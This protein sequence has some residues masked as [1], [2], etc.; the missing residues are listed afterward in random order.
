LLIFGLG[1]WG[2]GNVGVGAGVKN[3]FDF[4]LLG[5]LDGFG[6]D[7]HKRKKNL[8]L[9]HA[10]PNVFRMSSPS[11]GSLSHAFWWHD[12]DASGVAG[13]FIHYGQV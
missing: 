8:P 11:P 13:D 10:A 2:W 9:A 7:S 4:G 5:V 3:F 1:F 12:R 6:S